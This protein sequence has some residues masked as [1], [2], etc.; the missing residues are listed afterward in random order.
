MAKK[1]II[2]CDAGVDDALA[3]ILALHSPELNVQAVS[4]VNG[5]VP[6]DLVFENIQ[7]V[8]SFVRPENKPLIAKGADRPLKGEPVYA[9]SFHGKSGLGKAKINKKETEAWYRLFPGKADE[10][11]TKLASQHPNELTLIAVGPLTN[12]ALALHRDLEGMK[13]LKELVIMGGAVR[14][15]GNVTP[16]AEFNIFV[17]PLA[18]RMVFKSG[19]PITLVPLDVTHQ[20]CLTSR[21]MEERVKPLNNLFSQFVVEATQYNSTTHRFLENSEMF[22]LHDP[23]AVGVTINRD[24]VGMERLSIHVGTENGEY[25]GQTKEVEGCPNINACLRVN[26]NTFLELFL[27]RLSSFVKFKT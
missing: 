4:G 20:V 3:L 15:K 13:K 11:I 10:L 27:S 1:V 16:H 7:K 22:Y 2:D 6:L 8:L 14:V 9:Y 12:V 23:L 26:S 18:A 21:V 5:N 17:D 19:L 24:L 25:Y